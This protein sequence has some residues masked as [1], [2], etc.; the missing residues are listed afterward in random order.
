MVDEA[1]AILLGE[2]RYAER[3]CQ[4]TARLYRRLSTAG[5]F[6]AIVSGS[7]TMSALSS[8]VPDWVSAAGAAGLAIVGALLVAVRPVEKALANEADAR[9]YTQLRTAAAG[10]DARALRTALAKAHECDVQEIEPLRAVAFNDVVL[11]IGR[12]DQLMPLSL[13][14]KLLAALA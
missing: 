2:V 7:A 1:V 5:V 4:R 11:E 8:R 3:L 10:M 13:Q 6:L 14:Q 12:A 9:R